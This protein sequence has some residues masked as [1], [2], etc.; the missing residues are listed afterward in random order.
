MANGRGTIDCCYCR[1][2]GGDKGYPD[3][4]RQ[5]TQCNYHQVELPDPKELNRICCH[6]EPDD[7][8]WRDNR[9]WMPPA[10][11]FSWF[12]HDFEPGVLYLFSY[13]APDKISESVV[14]RKPNYQEDR[15]E[16]PQT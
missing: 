9:F 15:W 12:R 8:Y 14:L 7:T 4:Y 10:R 2:F 16:V 6:F 5:V 11:R 1:H 3:G 13:N